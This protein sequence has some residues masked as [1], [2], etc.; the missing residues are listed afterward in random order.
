M[1]PEVRFFLISMGLML[2][3]LLGLACLRFMAWQDRRRRQR[4]GRRT[5]GTPSRDATRSRPPSRSRPPRRQAPPP[6]EDVDYAVLG[7]EAVDL[8]RRYWNELQA[9]RAQL[10]ATQAELA[11]TQNELA[12]LRSQPHELDRGWLDDLLGAI[13]LLVIGHTRAGKTTLVHWLAT[14]LAADDQ[15]VIVCDLDAAPGLWPGCL[16]FGFQNNYSAIDATL[17]SVA[18]ELKVRRELRGSGR[19][20]SFEPLHLILDEYQDVVRGCPTAKS[21]V[22]DVLE[23]GGKLDIHLVIGVPD[24]QVGTMGFE[25]RSALRKHFTY[26]VEMRKDPQ[27]QR[28]AEVTPTGSS[29]STVYAVPPLPDPERLIEDYEHRNVTHSDTFLSRLFRVIPGRG[30]RAASDEEPVDAP[31]GDANTVKTFASGLHDEKAAFS[32]LRA[33]FSLPFDDEDLAQ[34]ID[35]IRAEKKQTEVVQ[36][37]PGYHT[38]KHRLFV[39]YYQTIVNALHHDPSLM[40]REDAATV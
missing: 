39:G 2:A 4:K 26:V 1:E 14:R 25:G 17:Q 3:A 18:K 29:E 6:E 11:A 28:W 35:D 8:A 36:H 5:T 37:M 9:T 33:D 24:Q 7:R 10:A 38:K 19:Q 31:A 20:R 27:G 32:T 23:R 34:I 22:E 16:V 12:T 15:Q 13:H 40:P 21:L 30:G